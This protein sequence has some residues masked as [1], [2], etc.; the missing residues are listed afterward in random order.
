MNVLR[1]CMERV[2]WLNRLLTVHKTHNNR[3]REKGEG[4]GVNRYM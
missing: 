2:G 3:T 4:R 1:S